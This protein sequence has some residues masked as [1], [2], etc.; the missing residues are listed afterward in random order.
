MRLVFLSVKDRLEARYGTFEIFGFDFLLDGETLT[1]KLMDLTSNP[2]YSTQ[3]EDA[4]PIIRPL[5][6][7]MVTMVQELH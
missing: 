1:P 4:K 2:S 5:I 6:R 3:M 7:D